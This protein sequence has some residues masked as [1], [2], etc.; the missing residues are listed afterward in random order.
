MNESKTIKGVSIIICCYN[1]A[2]RIGNTLKHIS[3]QNVSPEISW[4]VIVVNNNSSDDTVEIAK[5][6]WGKY[7]CSAPFLIVNE[8]EQGLSNARKRGVDSAKYKYLIFCDDD[9]WLNNDYVETV[10][11]ILENN[12]AI[13][14]I[15]GSIQAITDLDLPDWFQSYS[16]WYACGNQSS[17]EGDISD[18]TYVWGAGMGVRKEV[19]IKISDLNIPSFLSDR[20]GT[21]LASGGDSEISKWALLLGYKLW[22][23]ES[24]QLR[25]FIPHERLTKS[26]L[27][28]LFEG[29]KQADYWLDKYNVLIHIKRMN[30]TSKQLIMKGIKLIIRSLLSKD[31]NKKTYAQFMIGNSIKVSSSDDYA[32][33]GKFHSLLIK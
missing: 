10:L 17:R 11:T 28:K 29:N 8:P 12:P 18:R 25:H 15:G 1:S 22:Y 2:N 7:N 16:D 30:Y 33:S 26:Y 4:E 21:S 19:F 14:V 9:N 3:L 24:L 6:E 31:Q 5:S 13:G 32:L 23:T 20:K 27:E